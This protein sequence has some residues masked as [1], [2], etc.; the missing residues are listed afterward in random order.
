MTSCSFHFVTAK[1]VVIENVLV[2]GS[3]M[4]GVQ[5]KSWVWVFTALA[6]LS[7]ISSVDSEDGAEPTTGELLALSLVYQLISVIPV[8]L[9]GWL[10][11]LWW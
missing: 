3:K 5:Y 11:H 1:D 2:E 4:V 7:I 10:F 9:L 6:T 8:M